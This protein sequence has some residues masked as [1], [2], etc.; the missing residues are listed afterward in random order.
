MATFL[1]GRR[2]ALGAL[3][4]TALAGLLR[5]AAP[6]SLAQDITSR[7]VTLFGIL[8]TPGKTTVDKDLKSI[9]PQLRQLLPGHGFKL[10]EVQSKRLVP[11]QTV[12]CTKLGGFV[13]ELGLIAPI[14]PNGKVQL[15]Y[16]LGAKVPGNS[17]SQ[18]LEMQA[19]TIVSTPPN[20]LSFFDKE[21]AGGSRLIIGMGAR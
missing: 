19:A 5:F 7:Q 6:S 21:L 8:A 17:E 14:D 18:D 2:L 10:L 13:A 15:R 3:L 1:A 11:G 4:V 20:Q 12:V 9:E 16:A